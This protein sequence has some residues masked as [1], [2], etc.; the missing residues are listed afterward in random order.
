MTQAKLILT[1][2]LALLVAACAPPPSDE[3]IVTQR[4]QER[5]DA[6]VDSDFENSYKYHSPG[7]REEITTTEHI[8]GLSRRKIT[9]VDAKIVGVDCEE[10]RCEVES[11]VTYSADGAPG[12]LAG[13]RNTRTVREIWVRLDDQW[14]YSEGV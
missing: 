10:G 13:I 3:E 12:V 5:W 6:L 14:W 4:A 7:Y 11:S 1:A 8:V 2:V 9:W